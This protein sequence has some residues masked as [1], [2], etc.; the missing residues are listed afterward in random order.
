VNG[1][2]WCWENFL[3]LWVESAL[4]PTIDACLFNLLK[5]S[6]KLQASLVQPEVK[7]LG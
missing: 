5:L 2:L 3:W 6:L 4:T 7:S 1:S